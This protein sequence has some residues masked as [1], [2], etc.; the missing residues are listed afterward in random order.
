M[1]IP[2]KLK[3]R[4]IEFAKKLPESRR[5]RFLI[6]TSK[7][8][9]AFAASFVLEHKYTVIYASLGFVVGRILDTM[10]V[11]WVPG[12]G[13]LRPTMNMAGILLGTAGLGCGFLRD[14]DA[15]RLRSLIVR[16]IHKALQ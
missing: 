13:V 1:G 14:Y 10:L 5:A 6:E 8:I 7:K 12:L 16:Q 4:L 9:V 3:R 11:I 15:L 2:L